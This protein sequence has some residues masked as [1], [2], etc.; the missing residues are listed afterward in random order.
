MRKHPSAPKARQATLAA[1]ILAAALAGCAAGPD[2]TRP[3]AP[4]S[5]GYAPAG[6]PEETAAAPVSAGAAQR[7]DTQRDIPYDWWTL[8][9][10]KPLN[11]LIER[12]FK[13]NDSIEAAQAALRQAQEYVVAQQGYFSPTVGLDYSASRN[14]IAGNMS[15]AYLGP[16]GNGTTL[17]NIYNFHV[18][19]L[20]VGYAPD[21]FGAN[22][23]QVESLQ[24]QADMQRYELEAAYLTLASN[25]VA[26]ALQEASLRAQIKAAERIVE[27]NQ[28]S[29][30]ILKKQQELGDA[31]A[32]DV[33]AQ[34]AALA[35][36]KS[37]LIP[38]KKQLAQTRD[39]LHALAD[40]SPDKDL[41]ETFVLDDL[42]L[43]EE[44]PLSL[45]SKLV[46][47]R[48]DVRAA[49]E[50]L[51]AAS[52]QYGVAIANRLPQFSVT[53]AVGGMAS[54]P[55]WLFKTGGGFF[56]LTADV[57]QTLFDGGTLR[58]RSRA[59]QDALRETAAL[60][61]GTV[62]AAL[63]NVADTLHAIE[64]DAESLKA[65]AQNEAAMRQAFELTQKQYSAGYVNYPALLAA[66]QNHAQARITLA[67]AEASR[68]GDTAALYEALGGGWWN[69]PAGLSQ[70]S[71]R[72]KEAASTTGVGIP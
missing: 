48:P 70:N 67:Q 72:G 37:T 9:Q 23:R 17:N 43:P 57:A 39:L 12:A 47:Q 69:R 58:A 68:L 5:S 42:H 3:A 26:A 41:P 6:A 46:E 56:N 45:P 49:E 40:E 31:S 61:R 24:A 63:Q 60:Y 71:G 50:Q 2:F 33:S 22:R 19:Q 64:A 62:I 20:T 44:L 1:A 16:Q 11:D 10:S 28:E 38:L 34:E 13:A 25:V 66:E 54:T 21:I 32:L 52:A 30:D 18:A 35:Q 14:K 53:G 4:A 8:F 36:A 15:S 65:A 29:L 51:H 55:D 59:A 27:I 7:F